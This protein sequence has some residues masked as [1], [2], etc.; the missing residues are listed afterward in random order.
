MVASES[1]ESRENLEE[2]RTE[3]PEETT[4]ERQTMA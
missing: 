3:S 4:E 1:Q 2:R